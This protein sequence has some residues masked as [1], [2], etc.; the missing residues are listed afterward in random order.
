MPHIGLERHDHK[1]LA[2]YLNLRQVLFHHSPNEGKRSILGHVE[3][4]RMGMSPG[5]PDFVIFIPPPKFPDAPGGALEL[6]RVG[7][8]PTSEQ[9]QWLRLLENLKWKTKL[10]NGFDDGLAWLKEMG[11]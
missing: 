4:R 10:A 1:A 11:W 9:L 2:Q 5:F 3:Q 7:Q 8:K 6:K